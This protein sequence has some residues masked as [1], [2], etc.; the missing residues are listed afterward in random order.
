MYIMDIFGG[1]L[2]S[3]DAKTGLF[4]LDWDLNSGL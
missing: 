3:N 1:I 4:F 2:C